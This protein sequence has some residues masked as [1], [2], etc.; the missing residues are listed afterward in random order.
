MTTPKQEA[1]EAQRREWREVHPI[2]DKP[3]QFVITPDLEKERADRIDKRQWRDPAPALT[4][5]DI[6]IL[7]LKGA[8]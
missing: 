4:S 7:Q 1:Y 3:G 6:E 8:I 5:L 2:I